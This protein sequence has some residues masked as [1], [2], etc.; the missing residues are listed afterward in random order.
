MRS[1]EGEV[2][3]AGLPTL[4]R[5]FM[6][7]SGRTRWTR[8]KGD[9]GELVLPK[10]AQVRFAGLVHDLGPDSLGLHKPATLVLVLREGGLA[11]SEPARL[12]LLMITDEGELPWNG[13]VASSPP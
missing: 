5:W 3:E 7:W 6:W 2:R 4:S 13:S 8:E 12:A 10:D 1:N 9:M 11:V